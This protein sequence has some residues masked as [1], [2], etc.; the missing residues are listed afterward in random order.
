M[1]VT[2]QHITV[3]GERF[4]VCHI[5]EDKGHVGAKFAGKRVFTLRRVRDGAVFTCF[6][7][8]VA[9]NSRL[10]C[11]CG[12][13]GVRLGDGRPA[14]CPACGATDPNAG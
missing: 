13:N 10:L 5:S 7:K 14:E 2:G 4:S 8:T 9:P 11:V 12:G 3:R 1:I 6:G